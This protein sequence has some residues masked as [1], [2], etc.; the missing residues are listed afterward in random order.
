MKSSFDLPDWLYEQVRHTCP[1]QPFGSLIRDALIIALPVWTE[2]GPGRALE[3]A[4]QA[5]LRILSASAVAQGVDL[6]V[7]ARPV[8]RQWRRA[9]P[10]APVPA[11]EQDDHS[12]PAPSSATKAAKSSHQKASPTPK[13]APSRRTPAPSGGSSARPKRLSDAAGRTRRA[14]KTQAASAAPANPAK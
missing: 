13:R 8:G 6:P 10:L 5:E 1:N 7:S 9:V 3:Q 14:V 2:L 12:Q 11:A 4:L